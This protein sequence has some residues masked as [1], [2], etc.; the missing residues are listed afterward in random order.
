V[1]QRPQARHPVRPPI[2]N[3]GLMGG[4]GRA[5]PRSIRTF[6]LGK[7]RPRENAR[8]L[9]RH[10]PHVRRCRRFRAATAAIR[11]RKE[12]PAASRDRTHNLIIR[13]AFAR[14][15]AL[16]AKPQ[17]AAH[18]GRGL[19]LRSGST[20]TLTVNF[21]EE[22]GG[23]LG[24]TRT[25][26]S[27]AGEDA[28]IR[29]RAA[30]SAQA[31]PPERG[32]GA[33]RGTNERAGHFPNRSMRPS[34][35]RR[36]RRRKRRGPSS[37]TP[38]GRRKFPTSRRT[39]IRRCMATVDARMADGPRGGAEGQRTGR[40][41]WATAWPGRRKGA[42]ARAARSHSPSRKTRPQT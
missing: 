17:S 13:T 1:Q 2:R 14:H 32:P 39:I 11:S 25:R 18:M 31:G 37:N 19:D 33:A 12:K 8:I 27:G 26:G 38:E 28:R 4:D 30:G 23:R 29:P 22:V 5:T 20:V 36:G 7:A 3:F 21:D 9:W 24:Y 6:G 40:R 35:A 34:D 42:G 16:C 41:A 10:R 15:R